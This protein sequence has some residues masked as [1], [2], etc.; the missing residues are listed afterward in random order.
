MVFTPP[1]KGMSSWTS[2][3]QI[4]MNMRYGDEADENMKMTDW[5]MMMTR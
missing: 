4:A 1:T 2:N 5:D 3:D